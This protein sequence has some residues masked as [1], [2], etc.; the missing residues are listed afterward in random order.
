V[1]R[2]GKP[3][4]IFYISDFDPSGE[5]MPLSVARH[6]EFWRRYYA[7]NADIRLRQL[8]LTHQ[9]VVHYKLPRTPLKKTDMRRADFEERYGEGATELDALEARHPGELEQLVRAA[10]QPYI[11]RSLLGGLSDAREQAEQIIKDAWEAHTALLQGQ[12]KETQKV[13]QIV[14]ARYQPQLKA[15]HDQLERDLAP[16]HLELKRL[17]GEIAEA[18]GSFDVELPERPAPK[19]V[20]EQDDWLFDSQRDYLAQI[21]VYKAHKQREAT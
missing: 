2:L 16:F 6:L 13:V 10:V 1:E 8:A 19:T 21:A 12:L 15:L 17:E 11:D 7:P 14:V 5:G 20:S 9:Q 3:A 4:R 18:C